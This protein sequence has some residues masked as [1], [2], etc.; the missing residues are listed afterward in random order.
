MLSSGDCRAVRNP[1]VILR[2][3]RDLCI[4]LPFLIA[5][6]TIMQTCKSRHSSH[7]RLLLLIKTAFD[8]Y[9]QAWSR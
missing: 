1:E 7:L 4:L 3:D 2:L 6:Q 9:D 8:K 5:Q